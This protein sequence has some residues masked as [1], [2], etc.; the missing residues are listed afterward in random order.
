MKKL[1]PFC[2]LAISLVP[3][4]GN[5]T[6]APHFE[7]VPTDDP[8]AVDVLA[9]FRADPDMPS[10]R[11]D[12]VVYW[13]PTKEYNCFFVDFDPRRTV[14]YEGL[15]GHPLYCYEHETDEFSMQI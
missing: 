8:I 3:G 2:L 12:A 5:E 9:R 7:S 6:A 11:E 13:F 4:C 15:P 1:L 14:I 10:P